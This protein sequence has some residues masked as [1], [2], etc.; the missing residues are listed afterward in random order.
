MQ[1]WFALG[2]S[3]HHSTVKIV[4]GGEAGLAVLTRNCY[5]TEVF[6]A[7]WSI[8]LALQAQEARVALCETRLSLPALE[9]ELHQGNPN[10]EPWKANLYIVCKL[11]RASDSVH[12]GT[13]C[14]GR[15]KGN[16]LLLPDPESLVGIINI[17]STISNVLVAFLKLKAEELKDY[18]LI[19]LCACRVAM[20][21]RLS[22]T[23]PPSPCF[24]SA[25]HP[26][27]LG[28]GWKEEVFHMAK[29]LMVTHDVVRTLWKGMSVNEMRGELVRF[30]SLW[31]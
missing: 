20:E 26:L 6:C 21:E 5:V 10:S 27:F 3:A 31:T 18:N 13:K 17:A 1:D 29:L 16:F 19:H 28:Q 14:V 9:M 12:L 25:L 11:N 7:A 2:E 24:H 4:Q 22:Q 8:S 30:S 23:H 15:T